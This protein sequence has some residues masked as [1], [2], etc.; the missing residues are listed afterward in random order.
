[1][2][3]MTAPAVERM[4]R[5]GCSLFVLRVSLGLQKDRT[6]FMKSRN[7]LSRYAGLYRGHFGQLNQCTKLCET[8]GSVRCEG[9][10]KFNHRLISNFATIYIYLG[11]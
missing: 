7:S 1:M 6:R 3:C 9:V 4:R 10:N 8:S 11:I 5:Y 2:T